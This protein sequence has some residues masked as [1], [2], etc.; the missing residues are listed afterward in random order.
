M[1]IPLQSLFVSKKTEIKKN[2]TLISSLA[3]KILTKKED[4]EKIQPYLDKL[5]E[6]ID[7]KGINNIALTGGYGSGK[8]T[9]IGTFKELN[10]QYKFLNISLAS[11]N[12]KKSDDTLTPSEKKAQKE[13][14]E[15]L[16]EV[17]ILQQIFYHVKPEEI[18]ESRFK[19]II[20]IP[21]WKIWSISIGFILWVT[22]STLL[23]KYSYLDKINPNNWNSK[24][25]FDWFALIIFLIA[26]IGLGLFSK[27]IIKLFS[28]SK[29]NKVNIKGELELGDNVNKSV[30]N[31]H[32]EEILYFFERTKYDVV[33]IED[34]D[35]FDSTD[36][37]TKLREINIL[38]NNS[39]L[40]NRE[41]NFVYAVGDDL[42]DDKKERV[43]F[44]EYIIPV[45]PFINSSNA[46]EQLRTLIKEAGLDENIFT[47]EFISDV[48]TFID[49]I[50]M[51][52]LT[53]IFH[54][55]VIYRKT[56]KPEFI[57]KNDELFAMITYK[58]IDPKDFTKLNKKEGKLF[59]LI[60]NKSNYIKKFISKIDTEITLKNYQIK[61]IEGHII[62]DIEELKSIYLKAILLTLP[63]YRTIDI[64]DVLENFD[65]IIRTQTLLNTEYNSYHNR[66]NKHNHTFDFSKIENQVNSDYCYEERVELIESKHNNKVDLLKIEIE[67]LKSKK[68]KIKNWNL[69]QIFNEVDIDEYLNNFSNNS[70]LRNFILNGYI[71]ENYN[72][73]I[74]LFHEVSITKED[75]TFERNVKGGYP[76]DFNY[77]LSA[78]IENLVEK[79][80]ERYFERETILNFDLL[81]YL[82]NNYSK[83]SD[84]YDSI[85]RLLSNEKEKSI[86]FIDEYII[87]EERPLEIFIE[88]LVENWTT[89]WNYIFLE[90]NYTDDKLNKYLELIIRF[91]KTER[92][93]YNNDPIYLTHQIEENSEFLSLIKNGEELD[94]FNKITKL[95]K[96]LGVEF[97]K[98]DNP[99]DETRKLFNYVYNNNHYRINQN[100]LLQMF[101]LFGKEN[102]EEEFNHS[103]YSTILKSDCIPLIDYINS[104]ITTYVDDVYLKLE[105]NKFE[106][107]SSLTKLLNAKNLS[108][109]SKIKIIQKVETKISELK[110]ITELEIKTQLLINNKLIPKWN[111]VIDYYTASENTINENLIKFLEFEDVNEELSNEALD[112]SNKIFEK[113][114]LLCN[115]ISYEIYKKLISS[116]R[117][118]YNKLEFENLDEDKVVNLVN[119]I[120]N[121]TKSNYD[122]LREHFPNNHITLIERD[123][124]KFI[125]KVDYFETDVDDILMILQ[126]ENITVDNRFKYIPKLNEQTIIEDENIAKKVG[127]IIISKST[128]IAFE[129]S[130]IENIIKSL[131]SAENRI[132]LI[133]LYFTE[134]SNEN[135]ISL[136]KGIG[137]YYSELFVKK[138]KPIFNDNVF[139]R[140][141]LTKLKS[142]GLINS[143]GIYTKDDTKIRAI[144]NY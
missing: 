85:I 23:L 15:R 139:N 114:M 9:I 93:L 116:S 136:V 83:Y 49:D 77:K 105:D 11:F 118:R 89:F 129:F 36:I 60:N 128:K 8:S 59:E 103:N 72:D 111:N 20:N 48:T 54:E 38:L 19:R 91:S 32:L 68:I 4:V 21:D 1:Q 115:E 58:N 55:F 110:N 120:L 98:L 106:D 108:G 132:K 35:R 57:K 65:T 135:I 26:F 74:S 22:S 82:G 52:L 123:Y 102:A 63:N 13:E 71:N 86:Q 137:Y 45:I 27:L 76:T 12:K 41:I 62:T 131:D 73:Y 6:T 2:N 37:F 50:D 122:L 142:K 101:L 95:L 96:E 127:E 7:T 100:N 109:K 126:S 17:S 24:D 64:N 81:D 42:F 140:E 75:Y 33:L 143:F 90:C 10:P 70:L 28:N 56:L 39:K 87:N 94:Y 119:R 29:I 107:Q 40:I 53:N 30:F 61:D 138:H 5:N 79:I 69:K 144:A 31:E 133:I 121:T 18:P 99:N 47:K 125:E 25:S 88:K 34:L 113:S 124:N 84:K 141:L 97:E 16:L 92:I 80:D 66:E 51:R 117:Y 67:K 130:T 44:F 134:L 43:K 78:K 112:E 14:L 3:P 46:D 104:K